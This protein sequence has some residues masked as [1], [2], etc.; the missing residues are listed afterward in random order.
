MITTLRAA[1]AEIRRA[2]AASGAGAI[3]AAWLGPV[4]DDIA[5][6]VRVD[7]TAWLGRGLL[8]VRRRRHAWMPAPP[9][10]ADGQPWALG[11]VL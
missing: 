6:S 4:L 11:G 7:L 9:H 1:A 5:R 10:C 2:I 8:A 3:L